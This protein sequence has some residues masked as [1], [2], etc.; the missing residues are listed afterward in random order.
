M[1][2]A[3]DLAA[4]WD[5]AR[6]YTLDY[7]TPTPQF[8][9]KMRKAQQHKQQQQQQQEYLNQTTVEPSAVDPE[10][11]E[12]STISGNMDLVD[13]EEKS[14]AGSTISSLSTSSFVEVSPTA[15]RNLPLSTPSQATNDVFVQ[16][17]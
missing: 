17:N 8:L 15:A 7:A 14:Q 12:S 9:E 16:T 4:Y 2:R 1:I 5:M 6:M 3:G 10:Q 13:D 11:K